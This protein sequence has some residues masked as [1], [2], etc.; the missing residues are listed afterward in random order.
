MSKID[1]RA[2]LGYGLDNFRLYSEQATSAISVLLLL[3]LIY[4]FVAKTRHITANLWALIPLHI[5][6][7]ITFAFL[8]FSLMIVMRELIA[9][10]YNY[11]YVSD[12][13]WYNYRVELR[14]DF[15]IY[16]AIIAIIYGIQMFRNYKNTATAQIEQF[17]SQLMVMTG[18]GEAII[19]VS[20]IYYLSA[21]K[22]YVSYYTLDKEFLV[23]ETITQA[24]SKLDPKQ[25]IR[26]H[27][28]YIVNLQHAKEIKKHLSER[29]WLILKDNREVPISRSYQKELLQRLRQ[30]AN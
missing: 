23:R 11:D 7:W 21:A 16:F 27:R 2:R 24:E 10:L 5:G 13:F 4:L 25:F 14:K 9:F 30:S 1:E 18:K 6:G 29:K 19:Q 15:K 28:S 20:D 26:I 17:P 8:H 3:P 12:S 22:N